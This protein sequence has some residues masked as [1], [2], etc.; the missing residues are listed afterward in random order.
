VLSLRGALAGCLLWEHGVCALCVSLGSALG[1][2]RDPETDIYFSVSKRYHI[3]FIG[4]SNALEYTRTV[5]QAPGTYD[6][7]HHNCVDV[8]VGASKAAGLAIPNDTGPY[9]HSNPEWFGFGIQNQ[10]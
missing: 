8:V 10:H 6:L 9:D 3:G 1:T 2:L 7:Y 4:L 5:Q